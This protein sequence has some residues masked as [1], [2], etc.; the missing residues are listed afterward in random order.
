MHTTDSIMEK[1]GEQKALLARE[2]VMVED[3]DVLIAATA[4][5]YDATQA[6]PQDLAQPDRPGA[7]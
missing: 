7:Q 4:L 5:V 6:S 1:F 3:A 2:G